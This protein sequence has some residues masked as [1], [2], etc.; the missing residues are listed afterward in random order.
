MN[1]REFQKLLESKVIKVF[2]D[3]LIPIKFIG[4]DNETT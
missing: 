1:N 3:Q 2:D 4:V